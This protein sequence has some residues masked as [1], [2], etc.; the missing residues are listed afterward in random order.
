MYEKLIM[1][2]VDEGPLPR[3]SS[4][5][6]FSPPNIKGAL[7]SFG[8]EIQNQSFNIYDINEARIQSQK[9]LLFA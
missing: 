8:E 1:Y 6:W 2:N 9:Y 5:P 4:W 7:C 3:V